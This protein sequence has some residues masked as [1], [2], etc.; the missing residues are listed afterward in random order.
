MAERRIRLLITGKVQGVGFRFYTCQEANRLGIQGWVMN[1]ANGQVEAVAIGEENLVDQ[2]INWCKDG[3]VTAK[4]TRIEIQDYA[5]KD[6]EGFE[7]R[8]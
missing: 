7:V 2:F 5:G 4:V 8:R 1:K 6:I 3:P